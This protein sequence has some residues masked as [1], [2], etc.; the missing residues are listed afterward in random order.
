LA[1]RVCERAAVAGLVAGARS[2]TLSRGVMIPE[3]TPS[4]PG[5]SE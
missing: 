3:R 1:G 2:A 5:V 4:T